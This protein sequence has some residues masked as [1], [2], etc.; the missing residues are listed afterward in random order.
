VCCAAVIPSAL[1]VMPP[2]AATGSDPVSPGGESVDERPATY[3]EVF[4][5]TEYVHLFTANVLSLLGDQL[6]KVAL[7]F[8][9]FDRTHSAALSAAA[10]AV[11]YVPWIVGGPLL[12]AYADRLPRR[13]VVIACDVVRAALVA[14]MAVPGMPVWALIALLF[15]ANV[16]SPPFLS[17]RSAMMPEVLEGDK[18][19][20]A[21]GLDNIVGQIAQV[22]GFALGGPAVVVLSAPGALL[23]DAATF[24]VSGVLLAVGVRHRPA[25]HVTARMGIGSVVRDSAA[26]AAFV[27]RNRTLRAYLLLLWLVSM[28]AY[29]PEGLAAPLARELG[30]GP[31]TGGLL[32]A[33]APLGLALGGFVIGRLC[34]PALRIRLTLPLAVLSGVAL[35]PVGLAPPLAGVVVLLFVMGFGTSFIIPLNP[36]FVRAVPAEYR[37]RAMGVAVAGLN[38]AM[39]LG[40]V[41]A[42]ALAERLASTTVVSVSGALAVLAALG[43][44]LIWPHPTFRTSPASAPSADPAEQAPA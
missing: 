18:Y 20:V 21:N 26:G 7:A 35:L 36:L 34:P 31:R 11:S 12:S 25:A 17:A 1:Q 27:F 5:V 28:F 39:G 22:L 3:R 13:T 6:A 30:G 24:A 15:V 23:V 19:V 41:L 14:A 8:L 37:G 2:D 43:L 33:S 9:V 38:V 32:L 16:F 42:G 10:Y 29:A 4:A 44:S 40:I